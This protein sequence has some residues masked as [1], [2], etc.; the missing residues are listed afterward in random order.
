MWRYYSI[1]GLFFRPKWRKTAISWKIEKV[2]V[3]RA[4]VV[5]RMRGVLRIRHFGTAEKVPR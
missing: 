4:D 5:E 1:H 2:G 3:K